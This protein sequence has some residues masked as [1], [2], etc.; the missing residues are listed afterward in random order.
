MRV[1]DILSINSKLLTKLRESG[2]R[3]DDLDFLDA[4]TDYSKLKERGENV[5]YIISYLSDKY[6]ISERTLYR[7]FARLNKEFK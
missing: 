5:T 2:I 3:F 7:A 6:N 4:F 1:Y